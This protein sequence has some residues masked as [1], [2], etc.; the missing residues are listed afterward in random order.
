LLIHNDRLATHDASRLNRVLVEFDA[1]DEFWAVRAFAR[2]QHGLHTGALGHAL[3]ELHLAR[4]EGAAARRLGGLS[5]QLLI[6]AEAD[7]LM[8]LGRGNQARAVLEAV[9][10]DPPMLRVAHARLALLR[11]DPRAALRLAGDPDWM[12]PASPSHQ[13]EMLVIKAV[14]SHRLAEREAAGQA[15]AQLIAAIDD[16]NAPRAL[17]TAAAA[18]LWEM[19]R[20]V[21][22]LTA[23]LRRL[24]NGAHR[25]VFPARLVVTSLTEREQRV[26][27]TLAD[28]LTVREA[29]DR[30]VVSYNTVKT[31][32]RSIYQKLGVDNRR[33]AIA[34]AREWRL[35]AS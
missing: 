21:P 23:V 3:V 33:D 10:G 17:T 7:L 27:E 15:I 26:L 35:L 30:L 8:A 16:A 5:E 25:H 20:Y 31:Q 19:A 22:Q 12:S 18:E 29:A 2:A 34:R 24:S 11:D 32:Q 13:R 6:A 28:G 14:A 9:A 4:A 1:R